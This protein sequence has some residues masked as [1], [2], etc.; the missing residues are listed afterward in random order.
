MKIHSVRIENFRS[1]K[2]ETIIFSD[3][4]CFVGPNGGGKSTILTAL[5]IFFKDNSEA[6][7]DLQNLDIEDFHHKNIK[8]PIVITVT[9]TDLGQDAQEDLKA[10]FRQGSLIV[11]AQAT[12]DEKT[13]TA[14]VRQFG[15]RLGIEDFR[16]YFEADKVGALVAELKKIYQD[17]RVT[18]PDLPAVGT[19]A[20]NVESLQEYETI[21][22]EKCTLIPSEDEFYGVSRGKNRLQK[23]L[24]WIFI[25]AVKD[26]SSEQVEAKKTALGQLIDRNIR[27]K[28]PIDSSLESL[29]EDTQ[30]KYKALLEAN[31]NILEA[32]SSSLSFKLQNWSHPNANLRLKWQD[33]LQKLVSVNDPLVEIVAGEGPFEGRIMRFGHG[34]QRSYLFALLQ[35]LAESGNQGNTT[36]ILGCEEPE[37]FQHPPQS[38]YLAS[39]FQKLVEENAQILVCSHSPY[40]VSGEF[41]ESVR[42][43]KKKGDQ[44][45][46][47]VQRLDISALSTTLSQALGQSP[48]SPAGTLL[49]V[50]QILTAQINEIFFSEKL[51]LVEG[52]EDQAYILTYLLL[53]NNLELFRKK[54]CHIVPCGGKNSIL[55]PRAIA[56]LFNIPS[57]VVFD[58]DNDSI[59]TDK[60][61]SERDNLAIQ[62][63]SDI[64][65][66]DASANNTKWEPQLVM[67]KTN[68]NK[69]VMDEIGSTDW[70]RI[71]TQV[72]SENQIDGDRLNKNALFIGY[73]LTKAWDENKKSASLTRLIESIV[74]FIQ[75]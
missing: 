7:T 55:R 18:Y 19:K 49:K 30:N 35:E 12:W 75:Q 65:N 8:D 54:G 6:K 53:S 48:I 26:A 11:S 25:P 41:L 46:S 23:Y 56:K 17:L 32:L 44:Q 73:V 70:E 45:E 15:Q 33:D 40:F 1:F 31:A 72:K 2:D 61:A 3:Y 10:Y 28:F 50:H 13:G 69:T 39:V 37:L 21:H 74:N 52:L 4:V 58:G 42:L 5:N 71:A 66:Q 63:L 51:I 60:T 38:R 67:W 62:S 43:V 59:G 16:K 57:F 64:N 27:S 14:S 68:I 47:T 36:L 29:R 22:P 20:V 24:Q 34:L 9:F